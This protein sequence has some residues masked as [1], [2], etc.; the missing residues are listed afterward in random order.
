MLY[1]VDMLTYPRPV[2]KYEVR[3]YFNRVPTGGL[4][5]EISLFTM[6]IL[7]C[8]VEP[9]TRMWPS[10][11]RLRLLAVA[12]CPKSFNCFTSVREWIMVWY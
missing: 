5:V 8:C 4:V 11:L 7:Y 10:S 3:L 1:V 12:K 6:S 2:R 9:S